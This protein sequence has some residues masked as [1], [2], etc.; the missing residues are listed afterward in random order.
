MTN[1]ETIQLIRVSDSMELSLELRT[2]YEE[3][4]P[5][6]ERREWAQFTELLNNPDFFLKAISN[7]KKVIGLLTF[8]NLDDFLFI[9]YFAIRNA[10]RGKGIGAK[11]V[12][13]LLAGT[14]APIILEVDEPITETAQKRIRF[15]ERLNFS[16]CQSEYFQPPYSAN[17]N[18]IKML[19]MS[20]PDEISDDLFPQ[21]KAR[22]YRMVYGINE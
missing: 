3:A 2:I 7:Q 22:I 15:Y 14:S 4:F 1:N 12:N 16:V 17:K 19:L 6:D 13:Q 11:V 21:T 9:E 8:W 10:E 20:Y 18:T 5:P